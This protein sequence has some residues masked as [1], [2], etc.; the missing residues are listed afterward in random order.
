MKLFSFLGFFFCHL[1]SFSQTLVI[2]ELDCDTPSTD[3][4][5]FIE[6]KSSTPNYNLDGYL[7]VLFNGSTSGGN[8]SYF[9]I[10]LNGYTTDNNGILLIG[11]AT[12]SP[13]PGL[14]IYSNIIQNG[15][16]AIAIYKADYTD[17]PEG[18]LA[19]QTNL[20]DALAYDTSDA[21]DTGLMALLG[22]SEQ[23]N[24]GATNNTNSIQRNNDGTYTVKTPTPGLLNDGSGTVVNTITI[25]TSTTTVQEEEV[26][27]ITFTTNE[28][29]TEDYTFSF[30]LN[31][32]NF[33]I[34]DY[35]GTTELTIPNGENSI[36]T[37]ITLLN[38]SLT[39]GDE[40]LV[41]TFNNLPSPIIAYNDYITVRVI[42][43][44]YTVANFGT[45][46]NPTY[47]NVI[48]T[49]PTN[50]Y[51]TLNGLASS[52]LE[53][54]LQNIIA[55]E[56]VV[57]GQSYADIIDILQ[58]ADQNPANSSQIWLV[59][60][61]KAISKLDYQSNSNN[62]GK[63]NR[64]HTFPRKSAGYY[65]I[66]N[67]DI[68]DGKE[69]YWN[70]NADSLRHGN[71]DAH[72]LRAADGTEN[73]SRSDQHYGE[74]NGPQGNLGSFK[75]DVARSVFYMQIRY[76]ALSIESGFPTST[77]KM[78]DLD[79]LLEWHRNDPPDD[80]EMNRNN[81]IYTWQYN[82]NPFIDLPD[83][84]EYIWGNKTGST[85]NSS[86][87]NN[88]NTLN[89][90]NIYPNPIDNKLFISGNEKSY[91]AAI[92]SYNGQKVFTSIVTNN[93]TID[94]NLSSG[95]YILQLTSNNKHLIKKIIIK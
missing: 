83:L 63:W 42:D 71:S 77:G 95:L 76:K 9:T 20:I 45:P 36:S 26:L 30:T 6:L 51:N 69:I 28:N 13:T 1:I 22:L 12:V 8:S 35:T 21:D 61:E 93:Q 3:T 53:N 90:I 49:E 89:N 19:T 82:R 52:E 11:S 56:G 66:E 75:G 68:R 18:T 91:K 38:D 58:E 73:S 16:D 55:K 72:A 60:T 59:Y 70:T 23:I 62:V 50:Y 43:K 80:F 94:L 81:I 84:V 67:D 27:E 33:T 37:N 7:V 31:N 85:Y 2:N 15:A 92:F 40:E 14:L 78:G 32:N 17:F 79:T 65:S 48:S 34:D 5:E 25:S 74:Y 46:I 64:E 10:D 44:N 87:S 39:E 41:I 57:R 24:E 29:V 86:L 88:E 47:G 54:Q 4:E